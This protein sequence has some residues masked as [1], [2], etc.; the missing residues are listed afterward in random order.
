MWYA[1][2]PAPKNGQQKSRGGQKTTPARCRQSLADSKKEGS[3][4]VRVTAFCYG[5]QFA[6][7]P[8]LLLKIRKVQGKS[9][10]P[11]RK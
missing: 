1:F 3:N 6:S 2:M 5:M 7:I 4:A 11:Y 8:S 10:E 9:W